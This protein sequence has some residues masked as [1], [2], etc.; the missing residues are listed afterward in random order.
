MICR[1]GGLQAGEVHQGEDIC[2]QGTIITLSNHASF[3][4]SL[5]SLPED[6]MKHKIGVNWIIEGLGL[7]CTKRVYTGVDIGLVL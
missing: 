6:Y 1:H 2:L 5:V 7:V 4:G 3:S